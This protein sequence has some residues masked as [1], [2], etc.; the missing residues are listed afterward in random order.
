MKNARQEELRTL[1]R[2]L[3]AKG[4]EDPSPYGEAI[5]RYKR[6]AEQLNHSP[7]LNDAL[8]ERSLLL[9]R[10]GRYCEALKL[11]EKRL[12]ETPQDLGAQSSWRNLLS[13]VHTKMLKLAQSAPETAEFGRTYEKLV[14]CGYAGNALHLGAVRHYLAGG[15]VDRAVDRLLLLAQLSPG[16][17]GV[18]DAIELACR[19]SDDA[20]LLR[21]KTN[22]ERGGK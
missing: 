2:Q 7:A 13:E 21:F 16:A 5:E 11:F 8:V 15:A 6:L 20:R 4:T 3:Y 1:S 19:T 22:P 12:T 18:A 17:P 9:M 10:Q 14:R